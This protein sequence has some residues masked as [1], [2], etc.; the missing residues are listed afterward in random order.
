M[1][2]C[3]THLPFCSTLLIDCCSSSAVKMQPSE[4]ISSNVLYLMLRGQPTCTVAGFKNQDDILV[5]NVTVANHQNDVPIENI[6]MPWVGYFNNCMV[7]T[8]SQEADLVEY[9]QKAAALCYSVSTLTSILCKL[10]TSLL[11]G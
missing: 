10:S 1:Y 11:R 3:F 7:L 4:D 2:S 8:L 6:V 5:A 9:L